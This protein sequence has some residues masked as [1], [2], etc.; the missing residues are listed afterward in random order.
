MS[1]EGQYLQLGR[2]TLVPRTISFLIN[3]NDILLLRLPQSRGAWA[4]LLNGVGG[5]VERGEDPLSSALREIEEETGATPTS[6]S[7][8]GV[9]TLDIPSQP[10]IGLYVFLGELPDRNL[11]TGSEGRAEWIPLDDL[12][13][14]ELVKDLPHLIPKALD[15]SRS[16]SPFSG[17]YHYDSAG[18]LSIH[19]S[20][21]K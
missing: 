13:S 7:L 12:P 17:H 18:H 21:L 16:G 10:G 1:L 4:G 11:V 8:C 14:A 6:L 5:H 2:Y 3:D 15:C 9:I 19:F 20:T